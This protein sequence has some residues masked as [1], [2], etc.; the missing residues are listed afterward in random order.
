[1]DDEELVQQIRDFNPGGTETRV[2]PHGEPRKPARPAPVAAEPSRKIPA[3]LMITVVFVVLGGAVAFLLAGTGASDAFVYSKLVDEVMRS[4]SQY[5]GR[6]LR[7]EGVLKQGSVHFSPQPCEH[8][9]VLARHGREMPVRFPRCVVP[10][11][12]RDN[13]QMNVVVEGQLQSNGTFLA[14]E[15]IPR[16]P[17]KYEMRQRQHNGEHAPH[18]MPS[19]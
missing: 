12:F 9:F 13:M 6:E 7:V 19:S 3:W 1:M 18:A 5:V 14:N 15:V 2:P 17:S 8:R 16:C 4:P 11:T 10:D